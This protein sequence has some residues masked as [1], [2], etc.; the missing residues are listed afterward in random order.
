MKL[1]K[2]LIA[3]CT[4]TK[5]CR[6]TSDAAADTG[7]YP[8]AVWMQITIRHTNGNASRIS[9][10]KL[11][12]QGDYIQP[13]RTLPDLEP[14]CC[15]MSSFNCCFLTCIQISQEAGQV[16]WCSHLFQNFPQFIVIYTE[17]CIYI[18]VFSTDYEFFGRLPVFHLSLYCYLPA[19]CDKY[20]LNKW[21]NTPSKESPSKVLY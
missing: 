11:N 18:P 4:K 14:V 7:A 16:V 8:C 17:L 1:G 19:W 2:T 9:A 6:I 5:K 15:S 21:I 3:E 12:K 20:L 13:W 10:H